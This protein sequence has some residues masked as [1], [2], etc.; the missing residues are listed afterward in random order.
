MKGH[1]SKMKGNECKIEWNMRGNEC[2]MNGDERK[3]KQ[4]M[5]SVDSR[6]RMLSHPQKAGKITLIV[7]RKLTT[8]ENDKSKKNDNVI[9]GHLK[10]CRVLIQPHINCTNQLRRSHFFLGQRLT[11]LRSSMS[12]Y[13]SSYW[14]AKIIWVAAEA[15]AAEA[16]L[17]DN[18]RIT[19]W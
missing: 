18:Y 13:W 19:L 2:K 4:K 16:L 17:L 15:V 1:E 3:W 7:Y 14:E 9:L 11:A 10:R 5:T 12:L 8:W 6:P